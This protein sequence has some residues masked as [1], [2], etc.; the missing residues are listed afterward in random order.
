MIQTR[1]FRR[2][3][4]TEEVMFLVSCFFVRAVDYSKIINE[5]LIKFCRKVGNC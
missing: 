4:V 1:Y 3:E 5:F 2:S